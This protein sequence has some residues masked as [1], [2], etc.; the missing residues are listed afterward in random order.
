MNQ[1][2]EIIVAPD[3][4]TRL[5]TKGFTGSKCL[6]ASRFLEQSLGIS[7]SDDRTTEFYAP[8]EQAETLPQKSS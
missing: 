2:I 3:G 1:T 6:L 4:S 5:Q 7:A 8:V